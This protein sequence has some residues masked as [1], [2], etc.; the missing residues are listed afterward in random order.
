MLARHYRSVYEARED[1]YSVC[2]SNELWVE[3]LTYM[4]K[5]IATLVL[6]LLK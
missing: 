6:F 4:F 3:L 1:L 5:I 2:I